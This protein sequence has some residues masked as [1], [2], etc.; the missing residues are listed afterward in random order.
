VI[1]ATL[2]VPEVAGL[3][4]AGGTAGAAMLGAV[5][6]LRARR[7]ERRRQAA[8]DETIT[9]TQAQGANLRLDATVKALN[10]QLDRERARADE[11]EARTEKLERE[12]NRLRR[13][14]RGESGAR[15]RERE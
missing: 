15:R 11:A 13:E 6:A 2:S 4:T 9:I 7:D 5:N 3:I 10:T 14:V 8:Q 12:N 1:V